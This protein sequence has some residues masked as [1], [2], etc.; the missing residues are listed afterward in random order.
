M[1]EHGGHKCFFQVAAGGQVAGFQQ[2]AV[3][4]N[5]CAIKLGLYSQRRLCYYIERFS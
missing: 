4:G 2:A 1:M 3:P 5:Q